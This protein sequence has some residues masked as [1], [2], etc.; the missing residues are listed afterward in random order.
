VAYAQLDGLRLT[1]N[2]LEFNDYFQALINTDKEKAVRLIN[3]EELSFASLYTLIFQIEQKNVF[4]HLSLRNRIAVNITK[5]I[6]AKGEETINIDC[7]SCNYIE[8]AHAVLKWILA[9]GAKE[10]GMN[11]EFDKILDITAAMLVKIYS[12]VT[13]L[14]TI[15][16]LIFERNRKVFFYNDLVWIFFESRSP[17]NLILIAERFKSKHTEDV[18][19]AH[20]LLRFIPDISLSRSK[21]PKVLYRSFINWIEQNR[22]FLYYTGESFQQSTKPM[23]YAVILEAKYLCKAV[24]ANTGNMIEPIDEEEFQLL[25]A[26]S[27]LDIRS[28]LML[29]DYSY[30][31]YKKNV[32]WWNT[33]L[34]YPIA[35]QIKIVRL[36]IE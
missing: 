19:L 15:V 30:D 14:P 24:S 12:D 25:E 35:Q 1:Q 29:A 33:W 32:H 18:K 31:I 4:E 34:R 7:S 13:V 28:K 17:E 9:T 20:K 16:D 23:Q 10:D 26:F 5:D 21:N 36:G 11:N 6:L 8:S 2:I 3:D 27:G 22:L